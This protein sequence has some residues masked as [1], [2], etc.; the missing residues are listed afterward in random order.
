MTSFDNDTYPYFQHEQDGSVFHSTELPEDKITMFL[1]RMQF[2]IGAPVVRF[3][4]IPAKADTDLLRL[5]KHY[6][7]HLSWDSSLALDLNENDD[8]QALLSFADALLSYDKQAY[9]AYKKQR[10]ELVAERSL[11]SSQ[12]ENA[13]KQLDQTTIFNQEFA[14]AFNSEDDQLL[15]DIKEKL[16]K[17]GQW[18]LDKYALFNKAP[19]QFHTRLVN[20]ITTFFKEAES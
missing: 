17:L 3:N 10:K 13:F 15:L 7:L 4:G 20:K 9:V 1:P 16:I 14:R 5:T 19:K 2:L 8:E 18:R 6:Q 11:V 12:V